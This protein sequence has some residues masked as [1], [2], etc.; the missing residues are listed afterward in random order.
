MYTEP[1][2]Q[3]PSRKH[4][5]RTLS[6]HSLHT[7]DERYLHNLI[8][9]VEHRLY[10][11][12]IQCLWSDPLV[13]ERLT[14]R[15]PALGPAQR[16]CRLAQRVRSSPHVSAHDRDLFVV[17]TVTL[18][19]ALILHDAERRWP[20]LS[21]RHKD[22]LDDAIIRSIYEG[23][24]VL[25]THDPKSH[26]IYENAI[27]YQSSQACAALQREEQILHSKLQT[28]ALLAWVG[29]LAEQTIRGVGS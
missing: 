16:L 12:V 22:Q 29:C 2:A 27:A 14:R 6:G 18:R 25:A 19:L 23:Y 26:R 7:Q 11:R 3:E 17:S 24:K 15:T 1:D 5:P 8:S 21:N 4:L 13:H 20:V 9:T 10:K 28:V